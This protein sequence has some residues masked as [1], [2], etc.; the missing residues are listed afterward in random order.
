MTA[1]QQVFQRQLRRLIL[2]PLAVSLLVAAVLELQVH[3]LTVAQ[4]WVDH[5][6]VVL[7]R[8]RQLLRLIIDQETGVRGFALSHDQRFLQPYLNAEPLVP[9]LFDQIR[10]DLAD[11]AGQQ[12]RLDLVRQS[13]DR[14]HAYVEGAMERVRKNDPTVDS[15]SFSLTGKRIMDELRERQ[16][17]FVDQE[18]LLRAIRLQRSAGTG[19][20]LSWTLLG[21]LV[22]LALTLLNETRSNLRAV[23]RE[24]STVLADLRKRGAELNESRERLQVTLRSIGDA[25]IVT[26][27]EGKIT[28]LNPVAEKLTQHSL[29]QATGKN[30][31]QVFRIVNEETRLKTESPFS[32]VMR[33]GTVV[34]LANHT[35]LLRDDGTELS[36]DD[37]GAPIR[38]EQGNI[39]GVVL[40]FRDI[41]EQKEILNTLRTNEKLAAAGKLSASIAHEIHN[42][43][44]TVRNLLYLLRKSANKEMENLI[45]IA[46]QEL[47][48]VVQITKNMLSLYRESKQVI[49]VKLPEIVDSVGMLLQPKLRTKNISLSTE[50][51]TEAQIR[52]FPAEMRQV[53]SNLIANAADAVGHSGKIKVTVEDARMNDSAA[54]VALVVEDNGVGIPKDVQAKL[55]RPFFTTKG[56][57][58]TGLGLWITQGIV[59]K[60]GGY[61]EV[62]SDD[63]Q[64]KHG[65]TFRVIFPRLGVEAASTT[66]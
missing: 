18:E 48:R 1:S 9:A 46:E 61:I 64:E 5:S 38:D 31:D 29:E 47:S 6:D 2:V 63:S 37:S 32:K 34:G 36:I 40:V 65:T 56:E 49:P 3:R 59:A 50:F 23:D 58:G 66:T 27:A 33:L 25:V 11:N 45:G 30:L 53:V 26:D 10:T 54:A 14:W 16:Q 44:E 52:A 35:A 15:V 28:F 22:V 8:S 21:L 20:A 12:R 13:Y 7:A 51:L 60:H 39:F 41:T 62:T 57:N 4:E 55:F 19:R 43:L 17:D 42:P 24:Y